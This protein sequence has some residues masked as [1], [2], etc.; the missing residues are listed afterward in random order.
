M[1]KVLCNSLNGAFAIGLIALTL[2]GCASGD[3][4]TQPQANAIDNALQ[5]G[6]NVANTLCPLYTTGAATTKCQAVSGAAA[7]L[8]PVVVG[9][10]V[11]TPTTP[12]PAAQ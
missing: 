3:G 10:G 9:I 8:G 4:F 2:T 12:A 7:T 6:A 1:I 5:V 11:T